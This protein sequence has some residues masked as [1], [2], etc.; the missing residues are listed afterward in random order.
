MQHQLSALTLTVG[1]HPNI[2]SIKKN[3]T[4]LDQ[5]TPLRRRK[6]TESATQLFYHKLTHAKSRKTLFSGVVSHHN[7]ETFGCKML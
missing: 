5:Q 6:R 3:D 7:I 1:C 4:L 2:N